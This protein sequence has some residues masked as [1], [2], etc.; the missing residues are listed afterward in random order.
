[1]RERHWTFAG[2]QLDHI[3]WEAQRNRVWRGHGTVL[4]EIRDN[5]DSIKPG[6]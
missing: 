4:R 1:M 3:Q 6:A 2:N 5:E